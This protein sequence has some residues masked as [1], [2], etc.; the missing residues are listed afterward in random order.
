MKYAI[1]ALLVALLIV[2]GC[3]GNRLEVVGKKRG[4]G[5]EPMLELKTDHGPL[6]FV[7]DEETYQRHEV[8]SQWIGGPIIYRVK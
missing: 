5:G 4:L 1:A 6:W 2:A 8:G 7:A 3:S